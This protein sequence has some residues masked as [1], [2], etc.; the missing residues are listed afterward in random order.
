MLGEGRLTD[1][2]GQ[3][4]DFTT[5]VIIMTSNLGA[6]SYMQGGLGFASESAAKEAEAHFA[7][8]V[9]NFLRPELLN[10]IERIVPFMPL[11]KAAITRVAARELE[12]AQRRA[13]QGGRLQIEFAPEVAAHVAAIGWQEK[14]GARPL[15]RAIEQH[16]LVPIATAANE[17]AKKGECRA[18]V[19][20]EK[21]TLRIEVKSRSTA[22]RD[23]KDGRPA[24]AG[25]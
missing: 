11:D 5:S 8:E 7:K 20:L 9:R 17:R 25:P 14:Y 4:A 16:V 24:F 2:R 21:G 3:V 13:D 6:Q 1:A 22:K 12:L 23:K 10:R 19:A 15:K 18:H